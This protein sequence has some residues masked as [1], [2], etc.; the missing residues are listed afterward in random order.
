MPKPAKI[1]HHVGRLVNSL[2]IT[3]ATENDIDLLIKTI[4]TTHKEYTLEPAR[5]LRAAV[6][7]ALHTI[8]DAMNLKP[9]KVMSLNQMVRSSSLKRQRPA[10]TEELIVDSDANYDQAVA[11]AHYEVSH[12]SAR[13]A[14]TRDSIDGNMNIPQQGGTPAE[15]DVSTKSDHNQTGDSLAMTSSGKKKIRGRSSSGKV[16]GTPSNATQGGKDDVETDIVNAIMGKRKPASSEFLQSR[17]FTRLSNMAGIDS[18]TLQVKELVF[19]PVLYP[20]LYCYLGV[21]PPCGLL[22]HG[23]SGCGKTALAYAIAGELGLPFFKA[24]GPELIGGTSGESEQRIRDIFLAAAAMAPSVLFIDALDVIAGKKDSASRGMDRRIVAQLFDSID[25][26]N[27][28]GEENLEPE[29][30]SNS[31]QTDGVNGVDGALT[32][33]APH[34]APA[35]SNAIKIQTKKGLVVLIA[36]TSK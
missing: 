12:P 13:H 34:T 32:S 18:I 25:N 7:H 14:R 36:A 16:E 6:A 20:S 1:L 5:E 35:A 3:T 21:Q 26:I 9:Q 23:P 30:N 28:L 10:E 11:D 27:N 17:P 2:S 15:K 31:S 19:Y 4:S 8:I 29:G 22:L 33:S 24:S